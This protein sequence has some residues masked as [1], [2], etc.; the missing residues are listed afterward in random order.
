MS[1]LPDVS[2]FFDSSPLQSLSFSV[3]ELA[4]LINALDCYHRLLLSYD[5]DPD[6]VPYALDGSKEL[7]ILHALNDK[8]LNYNFK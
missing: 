5:D 3:S 8:I 7:D 6:L 4:V 1:L 2:S